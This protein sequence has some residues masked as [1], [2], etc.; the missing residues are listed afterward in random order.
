MNSLVGNQTGSFNTSKFDRE[1]ELFEIDH[2]L[3]S[4]ELLIKNS[5]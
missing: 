3:K 4:L 1:N 2:K 5:I